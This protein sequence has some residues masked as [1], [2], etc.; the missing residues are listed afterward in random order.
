[1]R[2]IAQQATVTL[3]YKPFKSLRIGL[4]G[5]SSNQIPGLLQLQ[6]IYS[7]FDYLLQGLFDSEMEG[8][9]DQVGYD[10]Q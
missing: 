7:G 8:M 6:L 10:V 3:V 2:C 4:L 9:D 5:F 1:M